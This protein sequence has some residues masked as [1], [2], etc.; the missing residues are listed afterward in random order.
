M[1]RAISI[2]YCF[3]ITLMLTAVAG[4]A[5]VKKD[6]SDTKT[7]LYRGSCKHTQTFCSVVLYS[8]STIYFNAGAFLANV[9]F[10]GTY[11]L[12]GDTAYVSWKEKDQEQ[13]GDRLGSGLLIMED[14]LKELGEGNHR[15][16]F[17]YNWEKKDW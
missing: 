5:T 12:K 15:H 3:V 8:D 16:F 7:V 11:E 10:L 2:T 13:L 17:R 6:P 1:N 4:C 14:G 9:D